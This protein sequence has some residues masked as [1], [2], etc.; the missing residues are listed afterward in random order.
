MATTRRNPVLTAGDVF[1][2]A[3]LPGEKPPFVPGRIITVTGIDPG[4][5]VRYTITWPEGMGDVG[6]AA[7]LSDVLAMIGHGIRERR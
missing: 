3:G 2:F 1:T 5:E 7:P 4:G 6:A